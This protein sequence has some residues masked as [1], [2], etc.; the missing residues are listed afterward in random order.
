MGGE[1]SYGSWGSG[2]G[3][4]SGSYAWEAEAEADGY[5]ADEAGMAMKYPEVTKDLAQSIEQGY[6]IAKRMGINI[7]A[8]ETAV[9]HDSKN[10]T[11]ASCQDSCNK[12]IAAESAG[13]IEIAAH[14]RSA[15]S[16][17]WVSGT[18][19]VVGATILLGIKHQQ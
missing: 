16:I 11:P 8:D 9:A 4:G 10:T 17:V 1:G 18:M 3:S 19:L 7:T 15:S 5:I 14:D 13:T 6:D 2:S 12:C